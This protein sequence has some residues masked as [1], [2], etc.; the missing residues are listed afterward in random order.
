MVPEKETA[1]TTSAITVYRMCASQSRYRRKKLNRCNEFE[2][3]PNSLFHFRTN[4]LGKRMSSPPIYGLNGREDWVLFAL[5]GNHIRRRTVLNEM[6]SV[7]ISCSRHTHMW[8][9]NDPT[10]HG[11][12]DRN[13]VLN[14]KTYA[15]TQMCVLLKMCVCCHKCVCICMMLAMYACGLYNRSAFFPFILKIASFQNVITFPAK[16]S[17]MCFLCHLKNSN[18]YH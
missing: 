16:N 2:F 5:V 7:N 14:I 6:G 11:I 17:L 4:P 3:H 9:H 15:Y 1:N 13:M 10:R 12:R 8:Y 18:F